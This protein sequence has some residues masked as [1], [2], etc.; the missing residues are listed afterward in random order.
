MLPN[1]YQKETYKDIINNTF[2][3]NFESDIKKYFMAYFK[4]RTINNYKR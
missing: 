4:M 2:L 3:L 1:Y